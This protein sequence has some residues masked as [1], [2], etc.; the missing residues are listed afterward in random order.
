MQ[1][2]KNDT[3]AFN[4]V[5]TEVKNPLYARI[6]SVHQALV[7]ILHYIHIFFLVQRHDFDLFIFLNVARDA[8]KSIKQQAAGN[9]SKVHCGK[10]I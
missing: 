10:V 5:H 9:K 4:M 3:V 8:I 7:Y 2:S 1:G 6:S